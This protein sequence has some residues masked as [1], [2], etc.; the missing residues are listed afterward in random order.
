M[1]DM[2]LGI[3]TVIVSIAAGAGVV[4]GLLAFAGPPAVALH[5]RWATWWGRFGKGIQ[6]VAKSEH[7]LMKKRLMTAQAE[8]DSLR[9]QLADRRAHR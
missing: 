6:V 3:V 1:I 5:Q 4:V 2:G 9:N 8:V 7:D